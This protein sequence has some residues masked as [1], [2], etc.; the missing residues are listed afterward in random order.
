MSDFP[1]VKVAA[2]QAAPVFLNLEA[3]VDKTCRLIDEAVGQR[4]KGDRFSGIFYTGI[5]LVDLDGFSAER[6]AFLH[7]A[8]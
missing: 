2:V 5:S 3:T 4:G 6:N 8:L 1:T 7:P